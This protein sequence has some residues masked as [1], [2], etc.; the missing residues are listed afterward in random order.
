[1]NASDDLEAF[2]LSCGRSGRSFLRSIG[3]AS[4]LHLH[5]ARLGGK[6]PFGSRSGFV[7]NLNVVQHLN[8]P[9]GLRHARGGAFVLHHRGGAGPGGHAILDV[10][11]KTVLADLGLGQFGLDGGFDFRVAELALAVRLG[12]GSG[13]QRQRAGQQAKNEQSFFSC[14]FSGLGSQTLATLIRVSTRAA[15]LPWA[16]RIPTFESTGASAGCFTMPPA[17]LVTIA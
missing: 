9:G 8:R 16:R 17:W 5:V 2:S 4:G 3:G 13:K 15:I 10:D 14:R 12:E 7:R 1:M 6:L 11:L